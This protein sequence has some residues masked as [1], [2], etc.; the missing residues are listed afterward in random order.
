MADI[1]VLAEA[2]TTDDIIQRLLAPKVEEKMGLLDQAISQKETFDE[3]ALKKD[4]P[5]DTGQAV[6]SA[7]LGLLPL[8]IGGSIGG[9]AGLKGGA[10]GGEKASGTYLTGL[11]EEQERERKAAQKKSE[12]LQ[13]TIDD[14]RS[15]IDK[16]ELKG[17]DL[18]SKQIRADQSDRV[19][20]RAAALQASG[21]TKLAKSLEAKTETTTM[22]DADQLLTPEQI[23]VLPPDIQKNLKGKK[24]TLSEA[25]PLVE[26]ANNQ[27]EARGLTPRPLSETAINK[28]ATI[29]K[30][31]D[32]INATDGIWQMLHKDTTAFQRTVGAGVAE[33]ANAVGLGRPASPASIFNMDMMTSAEII[34]KAVSPDR[35]TDADVERWR[36]MLPIAGVDDLESGL[37]KIANARRKAQFMVEGLKRASKIGNIALDQIE[38]SKAYPVKAGSTEYKIITKR[39]QPGEVLAVDRADGT[40]EIFLAKSRSA[41]GKVKF[42]RITGSSTE[43]GS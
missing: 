17:I 24:I 1:N 10:V 5:L 42:V 30:G 15:D 16:A 38:F 28:L 21:F 35:F 19:R 39:M 40:T 9:R 27:M 41:N 13:D 43:G 29:G 18:K 32:E 6:F 36:G 7:I 14:L 34:G 26:F 12:S 37:V 11:Q 8:A 33:A 3:T 20:M 4:E 22:A 25:K 31:L 23:S 2:E